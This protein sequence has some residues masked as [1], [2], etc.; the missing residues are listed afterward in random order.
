MRSEAS[1]H[2]DAS[3]SLAASGL[4]LDRIEYGGMLGASSASGNE[5]RALKN[6]FDHSEEGPVSEALSD[7]PRPRGGVKFWTN[8]R[9]LFKPI[10]SSGCWGLTRLL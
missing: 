4:R 3:C 7:P 6:L 9:P 2:S 8:K 5:V 1:R 10:T